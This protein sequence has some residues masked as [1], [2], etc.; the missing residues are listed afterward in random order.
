MHP[1]SPAKVF[2]SEAP[3]NYAMIESLIPDGWSATTLALTAAVFL[4]AGLIKGIAGAGLPT[5]A[6]ALLALFIDIKAA[7]ALLVVPALITNIWQG[8]TG[9]ALVP[10]AKR[11]A[12]MLLAS[13]IGIWIGVEILSV[14]DA[15]VLAGILGIVL[16]FYAGYSLATPQIAPPSPQAE[17]WLGPPVGITTGILFGFTGSFLVPGVL[18]MQALGFKRDHF[19][20]AM[21]IAF[22]FSTFVLWIFLTGN[23]L[24][25]VSLGLVS[26]IVCI[27][28]ILGMVLGQK[29]RSGMSEEKFRKAFFVTLLFLSLYIVW[30]AFF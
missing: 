2:S 16:F 24:F 25:S 23:G 1:P 18:Y 6:L 17:I 12:P 8:L 27:P 5:V 10:I 22:S 3:E 30:R 9:G 15:K 21:G 7:I 4:L 26:A 20:Q 11:L 28:A 29:L 19:V 13:V 14:G